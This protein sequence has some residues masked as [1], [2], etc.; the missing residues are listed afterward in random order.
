MAV[1]RARRLAVT[2][3]IAT[4]VGLLAGCTPAAEPNPSTSSR[5]DG[6]EPAVTHNG[7]QPTAMS[8]EDGVEV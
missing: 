7:P 6:S 4:T 1:S 5:P 8:T 3:V 2:L